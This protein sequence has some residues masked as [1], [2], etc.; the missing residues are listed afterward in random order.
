MSTLLYRVGQ[1]LPLAM[2]KTIMVAEIVSDIKS[3]MRTE[4]FSEKYRLSEIDLVTFFYKTAKA[5]VADC[6]RIEIK[7]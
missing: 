2:K 6:S 5:V 1:G 3:G 4:D 7:S